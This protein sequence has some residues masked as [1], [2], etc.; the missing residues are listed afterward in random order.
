MRHI[1]CLPLVHSS[2]S[3]DGSELPAMSV[4]GGS[5]HEPPTEVLARQLE[6]MHFSPNDLGTFGSVGA[7]EGGRGGGRE[8][9]GA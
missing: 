8:G 3:L 5:I 4:L 9:E 7:E 6:V 2:I 1:I